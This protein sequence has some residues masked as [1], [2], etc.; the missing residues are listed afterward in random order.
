[1]DVNLNVGNEKLEHSITQIRKV[2]EPSPKKSVQI[3]GSEYLN[4]IGHGS[5]CP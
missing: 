3:A 5:S 4:C 2:L 1:M